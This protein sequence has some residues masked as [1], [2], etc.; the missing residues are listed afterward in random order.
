MRLG[1]NNFGYRDRATTR[2]QGGSSR[3]GDARTSVQP[4][5]PRMTWSNI[6]GVP[7]QG[8]F[9]SLFSS[10]GSFISVI[11]LPFLGVHWPT[12]F[13]IEHY[14]GAKGNYAEEAA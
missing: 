4:R 2:A 13:R 12:F 6:A 14:P 8:S 11:V 9:T 5:L 10:S 1:A 7:A 3:D